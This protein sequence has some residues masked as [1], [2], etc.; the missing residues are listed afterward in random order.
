MRFVVPSELSGERLDI[1]LRALGGVSRREARRLIADGAVFVDDHRVRVQS[2]TVSA[3]ATIRIGTLTP[4][5]ENP[6]LPV[7]YKD[8]DCVAIAK[9]SGM[10]SAPTR[11]AAAGTALE[12][13]QKQL[14]TRLQL[15]HRLDHDTSGVLLFARNKAA[16][17]RLS[18]SFR[19]R[20]ARRLYLALTP[21]PAFTS[22]IIDLPLEM[23]PGGIAVV[24]ERGRAAETLATVLA[25]GAERGRAHPRALLL[26]EPITGRTHQL[27]AHLAAMSAPLVGDRKYG[28][29]E[30]DA[31]G[32]HAAALGVFG[33]P[34]LRAP[35]PDALRAALVAARIPDA[36]I[37]AALEA[38]AR[39]AGEGTR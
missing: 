23:A 32:L 12:I 39:H 28:G 13:A 38:A 30:S 2:R 27:R 36:A 18:T 31:F 34:V 37:D 5:R 33:L 21:S 1:A 8:D 19:E 17:A 3:G 10:P 6:E 14:D 22:T 20:T 9:P 16:A 24:S 7:L 4:N 26:V 15:V 29:P 25:R 35:L 11:Q